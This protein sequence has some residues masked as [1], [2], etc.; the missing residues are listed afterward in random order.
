M[1]EFSI[2]GHLIG[3]EITSAGKPELKVAIRGTAPLQQVDIIKEGKFIF[4][5]N[6]DQPNTEFTFR[7]EKF[8]GE[9]CYYY[10]RVIQANKQM[11]WASPIW[12]ESPK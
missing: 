5:T 3:E 6:P 1:V 4:T 10:V 8:N 7:D 9:E 2:D 12:V 11:A